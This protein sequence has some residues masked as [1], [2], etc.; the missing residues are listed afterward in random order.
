MPK[1]PTT[2]E[3]KRKP[4]KSKSIKPAKTRR[5]VKDTAKNQAQL[6][7]GGENP[8][9][10]S[11]S[12][13]IPPY[14]A[15]GLAPS[16]CE[17]ETLEL[18]VAPANGHRTR[19][20]DVVTD[21]I[22]HRDQIN[23]SKASERKKFI[24][25]LAAKLGVDAPELSY[26]DGELVTKSD[27]ADVAGEQESTAV[28]GQQPSAEELLAETEPE[29]VRAAEQLLMSKHLL[30]ELDHDFEQLGIVG[31]NDL[32]RTV[33]FV[34]T[35]R[36]LRKP[37]GAIVQ[38]AS[39]SGKS[40]VTNSVIRLF[41]IEAVAKATDITPQALYYMPQGHLRNK[42][43][44]VAERKHMDTK[45]AAGA[46][47]DTLQLREMLSSGELSKMVTVKGE[48]GGQ[49]T[50]VLT[51]PGPIAYLETTTSAEIFDEDAT[52]LLPLV[53][54]ESSEQTARIMKHAAGLAAG[55]GPSDEVIDRII[56]KHHAAQRMLERFDVA[57]PFADKLAIPATKLVARRAYIQLLSCIEAVALFRQKQKKKNRKGR[58][59]AS[60]MDYRI[61][62]KL[63]LPI[64]RRIFGSVNEKSVEL[65]NV[66]K[67]N[68]REKP[69]TMQNC[70]EWAERS[71]ATIRQ[72]LPQLIDAE[73]VQVE[74]YEVQGKTTQYRLVAEN[75]DDLRGTVGLI[76]PDELEQV[77]TAERQQRE[78]GR[79]ANAP[80][81][82]TTKRA[83]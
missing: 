20:V 56:K 43:V 23:T 63:M 28:G 37:L 82:S 45:D 15:T 22:R 8:V 74:G 47:N 5:R 3:T 49:V 53:T 42:F 66:I 19:T 38:A 33:W 7:A 25:N 1:K 30:D 10:L 81:K 80:V 6:P 70:M 73:L 77:L 65:F 35:S 44:C 2:Q 52:R 18:Y 78:Q 17:C 58:I 61:A 4:T 41:P 57:I 55:R 51:Q 34:G 75:A 13:A 14:D 26:L 46:A 12:K 62:Y 24:N 27:S 69:F 68:C 32:A 31:E 54:D 40:H 48:N 16:P 64:V 50:Q 67:A 11:Q 36:L 29:I 83:A 72:R 21:N 60:V 59:T 39:S 76:S 9:S 71:R 79:L